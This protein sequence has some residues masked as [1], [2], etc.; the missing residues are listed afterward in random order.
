[1]KRYIYLL[2]L[3]CLLLIGCDG[4]LN[5]K[6]REKVE[7]GDGSVY[8]PEQLLTGAYGQFSSWD[9]AFSFL[10][11]TSII[12]D[13]ANKGSSPSDPGGDKTELDNLT[14][15][16]SAGSFEAMWKKWYNSIGKATQSMEYTDKFNMED[17]NLAS[18]YVAEARYLRALNYF[19]LVRGW[20]DI[21]IQEI[22]NVER[23]PISVVYEYIIDDLK[24]AETELP[25]ASQ[26]Q[27]KDIGRATKG[28]AQ[29]LLAKVYLYM[30]DY[31]NAAEYAQKVISSNE[32]ELM[33]DYAEVFYP[34]FT[35]NK[36][37][38]FE[39]QAK[40]ATDNSLAQGIQQYSQT[41]GARGGSNPW[42]WG[43][44]TPSEDLLDA[45]NAENDNIRR[46]GTIIFQNSILYDGREIGE[47][48]NPRYNYKAYTS[49]APGA[50]QNNRTIMYMRY[51]EILLIKAEA[52]NEL[53]N[54]DDA[55]INLNKVRNR[56]GLPN[57]TETNQNELRKLIWKERRLELAM[58]HDRWFDL[59]RTGEAE[60][61]MKAL[62]KPFTNKNWL[63]PIP[64]NQIAQIPSFVQNPGW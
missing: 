12:S 50:D 40:S 60:S 44:N 20:G 48:E 7:E 59:I 35:N 27:S 37:S 16:S 22:D 49:V 9:Y 39:F 57:I 36:E 23:Q 2:L 41:Q 54:T 5:E 10:G 8:T 21:P 6:S 55:L 30:K 56:V 17:K 3:P 46:D 63:F 32:Y 14:Y 24:L 11:I 33:S 15:T 13:N 47:T 62:G 51:A 1:M 4:F 45:Y 58:E 38:I 26:Y 64:A 42:G 31:K 34:E 28:A 43:F 25:M 18:R 53:G 19:F 61:V 29:G 52:S